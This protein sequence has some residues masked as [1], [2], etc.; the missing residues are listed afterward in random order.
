M[1]GVCE[2]EVEH[3]WVSLDSFVVEDRSGGV[4]SAEMSRSEESI[5]KRERASMFHPFLVKTRIFLGFFSGGDYSG[6]FPLWLSL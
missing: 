5:E 4:G 2:R 6:F 1:I 3:V